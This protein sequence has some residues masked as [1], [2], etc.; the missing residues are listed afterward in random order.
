MLVMLL[1]GM[2]MMQMHEHDYEGFV[3]MLLEEYSTLGKKEDFQN[4]YLT[5]SRYKAL[6][7]IATAA[8]MLFFFFSVRIWRSLPMIARSVDWFLDS[9]WKK[10][11]QFLQSFFELQKPQKALLVSTFCMIAGYRLYYLLETPLLVDEVFSYLHFVNKGFMVS[12][13]FYPGPN[14]H[15]FYN[16]LCSLLGYF[17]DDP[18]LVMRLPVF[19]LGLMTS[20][21]LFIIVKKHFDFPI[22]FTAYILYSF[23]PNV[24]MYSVL[25]RGYILSVLFML[26]FFVSVVN[27]IR[28]RDRAYYNIAFILSASLGFYTIPSFFYPFCS[29][30]FFSVF[31]GLF[32]KGIDVRWLIY[33]TLIVLVVINVLY[34]PV[35]LFNGFDAVFDNTWIRSLTLPWVDYFKALPGYFAEVNNWLWCVESGG[36]YISLVVFAISIY[37]LFKDV[38]LS[39]HFWLYMILSLSLIPVAIITIQH[40]LPYNRVWLYFTFFQYLYLAI[41]IYGLSKLFKHV[42]VQAATDGVLAVIIIVWQ[43]VLLNKDFNTSVKESKSAAIMSEALL[44]KDVNAICIYPSGVTDVYYNYLKLEREKTGK[45]TLLIYSREDKEADVVIYP[46]DKVKRPQNDI[47]TQDEFVEVFVK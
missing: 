25:G 39:R 8:F 3:E 23:S 30:V 33:N 35:Y 17:S 24:T 26:I 38:K 6:K 11:K 16:Q 37:T 9:F 43:S 27:I 42:W 18:L 41:A 47:I 7:F 32:R 21:I 15:V 5:E 22:A 29:I 13:V 10:W 1:L 2:A 4:I 45:E 36:L 14:N 34:L 19:L 46:R 40:V 44:K 20:I 28:E 31:F 12:S